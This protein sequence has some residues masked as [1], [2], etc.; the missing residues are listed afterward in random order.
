MNNSPLAEPHHECQD[1]PPN[2]GTLYHRPVP[3]LSEEADALIRQFGL[4]EHTGRMSITAVLRSQGISLAA[5]A[6]DN[7]EQEPNPDSLRLMAALLLNDPRTDTH[8]V[9]TDS[10][11]LC[12]AEWPVGLSADQHPTLF[13]TNTFG[14]DSLVYWTNTATSGNSAGIPLS[15]V[16]LS[17]LAAAQ[18][19]LQKTTLGRHVYTTMLSINSRQMERDT[20]T[21]A[22]K[23]LEKT[24]R[25]DLHWTPRKDNPQAYTA[26]LGNLSFT[27]SCRFQPVPPAT[28]TLRLTAVDQDSNV[29]TQIQT[30]PPYQQRYKLLQSLYQ[31][32]R[33]SHPGAAVTR[34]P[35]I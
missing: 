32:A 29:L 28:N 24:E 7:L 16:P 13:Y 3:A 18:R 9:W 27:I 31:A 34:T 30:L 26:R 25:P 10:Q 22:A 23:L 17:P 19:V 33:K 5:D 1:P 12:V 21:L 35:E 4:A 20:M 14:A 6:L 8:L 11:N 2:A 15:G